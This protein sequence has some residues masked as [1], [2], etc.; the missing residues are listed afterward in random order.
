MLVEPAPTLPLVG[1]YVLTTPEIVPGPSLP[2]VAQVCAKAEPGSRQ[3]VTS[4]PHKDQD[5]KLGELEIEDIT[6][7]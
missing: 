7:V 6:L 5:R 1:K 4:N 2:G 3:H